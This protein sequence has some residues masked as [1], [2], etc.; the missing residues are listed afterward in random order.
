MSKFTDRL[1]SE[2]VRD[3]G[4]ELAQVT[5]KP[6]HRFRKPRILAGTGAGV[7]AAG[8][9]AALLLGAASTSPAFAVTRNH[10]G[11]VTVTIT[12]LG[13][14]SGANQRL[15]AL[16]Y[17]AQLVQVAASCSG[18]VAQVGGEPW[19]AK[20]TPALARA[21]SH[22]SVHARFDPRQIPARRMLVIAAWARGRRISVAPAHLVR[23]AAPDCLPAPPPPPVLI[24]A[25]GPVTVQCMAGTPPPGG[26]SG[27]AGNSGPPSSGNSGDSGN[28]GAT[29]TI[30]AGPGVEYLIG[31][32]KGHS[33]NS[34]NS[35][36]PPSGDS[37]NSGGFTVVA[38]DR[39]AQPVCP[40]WARAAQAAARA[41]RANH[42]KASRR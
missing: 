26:N 17:R 42:A 33:G 12:R 3:H 7:A 6:P 2:L 37:G 28:S 36:P 1:W 20:V 16:G 10:D 38:P 41:A 14:I 39:H 9:A 19:T 23:G 13:S 24:H 32:P 40:P 8:T 25:A 27:N 21:A 30:T 31:P 15:R 5:R 4:A 35:G 22:V 18:R 11:S 29:T 34:G